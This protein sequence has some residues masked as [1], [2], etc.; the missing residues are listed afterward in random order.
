MHKFLLLTMLLATAIIPAMSSRDPGARRGLGRTLV[1]IAVFDFVYLLAL[2]FV[3]PR[4]C[5]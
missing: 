5:W 1:S 3:Y 2:I 4:I